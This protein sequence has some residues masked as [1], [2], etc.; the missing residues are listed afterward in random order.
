MYGRHFTRLPF[1]R[2]SSPHV[3]HH[4]R[5]L[6]VTILITVVMSSH[7]QPLSFAKQLQEK[8]DQYYRARVPQ[9]LAMHFN[10]P[11][12]VAGDTAWFSVW[13]MPEGTG[14]VSGRQL[15]NVELWPNAGDAIFRQ[16]ILMH[17][18]VGKGQFILP[19]RLAAG[20]YTVVSWAD[21]IPVQDPSMFYYRNLTVTG[22]RQFS[23]GNMPL[24]AYPEGGGV[25]GGSL[26][27]VAI[28]GTAGE[29]VTLYGGDD[30][31][32]SAQ[33]DADGYSQIEFY[34]IEGKSYRVGGRDG[35]TALAVDPRAVS[36]M[37]N[38]EDDA[39]TVPVVL[40]SRDRDGAYEFVVIS[41]GKVVY[42]AMVSFKEG[43]A[44]VIIPKKSLP[45]GLLLI[46][47]FDSARQVAAERLFIAHLPETSIKAQSD[48]VAVRPRE[49]VK[50][51]IAAQEATL[52]LTVNVYAEDMFMDQP[53]TFAADVVL[54]QLPRSGI[55][56]TIQSD[57]SLNKWNTFLVTQ[58]WNRFAW[59]DV[60]N[61]VEPYDPSL[62]RYLRFKG[63]VILPQTATG[64]DSIRITF[65]LKREARVYEAS[66][67]A[68]GFFDFLLFFDFD[69]S[70]EVVYTI[71]RK[72]KILIDATI[73]LDQE[74]H[75]AFSFPPVRIQT[76]VEPYVDFAR[77]RDTTRAAYKDYDPVLHEPDDP[78]TGVEEELFESDIAVNLDDYVS[79]P[80]MEETL[81]EIIPRLQHRWRNKHHSVRVYL[82]EPDIL[83]TG[84]P[85]YFIDGVLTDDTDYFMG[86]NPKDVATIKVVSTQRKLTSMG[87]LGRNGIVLVTT[88]IR[89]NRLRVPH[90]RKSFMA[91][92]IARPLPYNYHPATS[93]HT[94]LLR[95]SL[96]F[97]RELKL[98]DRLGTFEFIAPDNPGRFRIEIMGFTTQGQVQYSTLSLNVVRP[99]ITP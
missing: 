97:N 69:E 49:T 61:G 71:D 91:V 51:N 94:P 44:N 78:N 83:A 62:G 19:A 81:R 79:F 32:T 26:N 85:L 76:V 4:A 84:E 33:L 22:E 28:T 42:A 48:R 73:E 56:Y 10:Q 14:R 31:V 93:P 36:I 47:V 88:K 24:A 9:M 20:M 7:A 3:N 46:S 98:Q 92:G 96:Y 35:T 1:G 57:W 39:P 60:W 53:R 90:T 67:S 43:N 66:T 30:V 13:L 11:A 75:P 34:A 54:S 95:S 50:L 27:R 63:R 23:R 2:K 59:R 25:V 5:W 65:F 99:A 89:E 16:K 6:F 12:Y 38:M 18:G 40:S 41:H 87:I 21:G 17:E 68:D 8:L 29:S 82:T 55:D 72:G 80:D 74:T 86:L 15:I 64:Y 77:F 58:K 45:D 52:P 37:V 70:E